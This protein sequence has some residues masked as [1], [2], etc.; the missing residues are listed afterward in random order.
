MYIFSILTH[1]Q[2]LLDIF[3]LKTCIIFLLI[4]ENQKLK[5]GRFWEFLSMYRTP[6]LNGIY[7]ANIMDPFQN[8][9]ILLIYR[10]K[11]VANKVV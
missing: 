3:F 2:H 1:F 7:R 9:V 5:K 11:C 6:D 4:L 10:K 8:P